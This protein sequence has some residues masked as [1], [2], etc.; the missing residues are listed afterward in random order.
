MTCPP[1]S[2]PA[3][4]RAFEE[5]NDRLEPFNRAMF[6]VDQALDAAL[7]RPIAWTYRKVTPEQLR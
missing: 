5:T 1:A 6:D 4:L 7:I 2:D 3:A